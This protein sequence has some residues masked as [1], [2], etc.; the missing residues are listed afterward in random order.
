[1]GTYPGAFGTKQRP[2]SQPST[3]Q[4]SPSLA[5]QLSTLSRQ[6]TMKT[7]FEQGA[8]FWHGV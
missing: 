1:M 8:I 5:P 4:A 6:K 3:M 7:A 2:H